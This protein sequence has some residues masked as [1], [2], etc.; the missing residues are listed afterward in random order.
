[1]EILASLLSF[2]GMTT[3]V[4]MEPTIARERTP[5]A[6][7]I[8]NRTQETENDAAPEIPADE[9]LVITI[10]YIPKP[11]CHIHPKQRVVIRNLSVPYEQQTY[12]LTKQCLDQSTSNS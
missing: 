11:P 1:M 8:L 9:E 5:S 7:T 3:T 6:Q 2:I 12:Y 10:D 4:E